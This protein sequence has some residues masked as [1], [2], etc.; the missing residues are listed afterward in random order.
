MA[1]KDEADISSGP[2]AEAFLEHKSLLLNVAYSYVQDNHTA[3]DIV[4]DAITKVLAI[5][6]NTEITNP[7]S[8]LIT[9]VRNRALNHLSAGEK[10]YSVQVDNF[11]LLT[12]SNGEPDHQTVLEDKERLSLFLSALETLPPQCRRV[13]ILKKLEGL[14]LKEIAAELGISV[15]TVQKHLTKALTRCTLYLAE[16]G[17]D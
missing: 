10:K 15:S 3:E 7:K 17:Y 2:I 14:S 13:L 1:Q 5:A 11:V 12:V 8:Y 16:R 6:K 4:Q 9:A